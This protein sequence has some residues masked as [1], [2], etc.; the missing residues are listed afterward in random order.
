[1]QKQALLSLTCAALL[2][3][4][5]TSPI[6]GG[7]DPIAKGAAGGQQAV[8]AA[9]RLERCAEPLG[10][11]GFAEAPD[12]PYVPIVQMLVQQSNCFIVVERGR[13]Y[14]QIDLERQLK[15][16]GLTRQAGTA[17]RKLLAADYT[18]VPSVTFAEPSGFGLST[19]FGGLFGR[20]G[21]NVDTSAQV[22]ALGASTTLRLIDN[23]S[24]AQ[25]VAAQG[26]AKNYNLGAGVGILGGLVAGV[27][28]YASTPQGKIVAAAFL[29]AYNKLVQAARQYRPQQT[30]DSVG[31]G[32]RLQG[33]Q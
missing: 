11:V 7:D 2:A 20:R 30:R 31:Q 18:M 26:S 12:D 3:G 17:N 21:N 16:A 14:N 25:I 4:C 9:E 1:M 27:N 19:G 33:P 13:A 15:E 24:G 5:A 8:D 29:D 23:A 28:A 32:G 6:L 10:T 22:Q